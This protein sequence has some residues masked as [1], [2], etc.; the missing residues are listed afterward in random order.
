MGEV[1]ELRQTDFGIFQACPLRYKNK[2]LE[3]KPTGN[4]ISRYTLAGI[5][6]QQLFEIFFNREIWRNGEEK[7]TEILESKLPHFFSET[8]KR[9]K[10]DW[11]G[12]GQDEVFEDCRSMIRPTVALL[13]REGLTGTFARSEVRISVPILK[14]KV[15]LSGR[16][17]FFFRRDR[18]FTVL[19]G[20]AVRDPSTLSTDQLA[21]Y[22]LIL[23]RRYGVLPGRTGFL[24]FRQERVQWEPVNKEYLLRIVSDIRSLYR[25]VHMGDMPGNPSSKNCKH[26][27]F[28]SACIPWVRYRDSRKKKKAKPEI[29]VL[30]DS[31]DGFSKVGF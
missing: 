9:F 8:S 29:E 15:L 25:N 26:C 27:E 14:G 18:D 11:Y 23:F 13:F 24:L 6:I 17:D 7:S 10:V 4:R 21:F 5:V 12:A 3:G 30:E 19:D 2:V 31:G 22:A 28:N 16:V 1:L 20:K